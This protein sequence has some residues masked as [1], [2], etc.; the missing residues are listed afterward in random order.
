MV[1]RLKS[2]SQNSRAKNEKKTADEKRGFFLR[3][4]AIEKHDNSVQNVDIN[5]DSFVRKRE[6]EKNDNF[7]Q[8]SRVKNRG[9]FSKSGDEKNIVSS[10]EKRENRTMKPEKFPPFSRV[11]FSV[12][13]ATPTSLVNKL[14]ASSVLYAPTVAG[15]KLMFSVPSKDCA[16][17]IALLD[18]LCYNY[19][20]MAINGVFAYAFS[21]LKRLG[22]IVGILLSV[23]V[24]VIY[25]FFVVEIDGDFS[26]EVER[27]L[28]SHG[29]A[30]GKFV[31]TFDSEKIGREIQSLDGVSFASV[32]RVGTRVRVHV[33]YE[34]DEKPFVQYGGEVKSVCDSVVTRIVVFGGTCEVEVGQAVKSGDV[35]IGGYF[36][37]G[38]EKV[39][40]TASGEVYGRKTTTKTRFFADT[41]IVSEKGRVKS[42]VRLSVF[43]KKPKA[44]KSP[45]ENYELRYDERKNDFLLPYTVCRWTFTEIV[46]SEKSNT[47]TEKEMK[48]L[49]YSS[50]I[51]DLAD[52]KVLSRDDE[53]QRTDGG[54]IVKTTVVTEER[55]DI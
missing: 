47:L 46:Q 8:K 28:S 23:A 37:V 36:L 31:L 3:K 49:T 14:S 41:Y 54:Y 45:Y 5:R 50:L 44:P 16:K 43:G 18:E 10:P 13:T 51:E 20:I 9:R 26:P 2:N 52:V 34:Q 40:T 6:I 21:L 24:S 32:E 4:S 17:I 29:I 55:I 35:L 22:I 15:G 11:K 42:H 25:S 7:S 19:K 27:V 39:P 53:I 48:D 33:R 1:F 30:E 12:D 38:D